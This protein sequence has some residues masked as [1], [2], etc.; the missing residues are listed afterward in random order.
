MGCHHNLAERSRWFD[1]EAI[2]RSWLDEWGTCTKL[3]DSVAIVQR[4]SLSR[5]AQQ[6]QPSDR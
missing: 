4:L 2:I 5:Y 3:G 1:S 6:P